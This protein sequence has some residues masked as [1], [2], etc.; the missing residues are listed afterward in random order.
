M[1]AATLDPTAGERA[2]EIRLNPG[3]PWPITDPTNP[4]HGSL[5]LD[6]REP[7]GDAPRIFDPT[8]AECGGRSA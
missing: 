1:S 3:T 4:R 6:R 7:A 5:S 8:D 2:R